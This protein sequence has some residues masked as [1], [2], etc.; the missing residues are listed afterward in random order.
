[1][2]LCGLALEPSQ[3]MIAAVLFLYEHFRIIRAVMVLFGDCAR[4]ELING[5]EE[6]GEEPVRG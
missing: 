3:G 4:S 5:K 2:F 6:T 1:M